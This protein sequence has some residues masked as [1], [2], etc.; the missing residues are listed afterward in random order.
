MKRLL[1]STAIALAMGSVIAGCGKKPEPAK[2]AASA[3]ASAS[4]ATPAPA[5]GITKPEDVSLEYLKLV[6]KA[7]GAAAVKFMYVPE[8]NKAAFPAEA[9]KRITDSQAKGMLTAMGEPVVTKVVYFETIKGDAPVPI[10]EEEVKT[11]TL[12]QATIGIKATKDQANKKAGSVEELMPLF[13]I[14]LEDGWKVLD[15]DDKETQALLMSKVA[16]K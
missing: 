14:K 8:K 4:A 10:K 16:K 12:C 2:P 7:D 3:T 11:G 15:M 5:T 1:I 13:L 6:D 9:A